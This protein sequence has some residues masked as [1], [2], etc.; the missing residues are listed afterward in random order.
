METAV[1]EEAARFAADLIRIDTTNRG[2]GDARER[3]AA[4]YVAARLTEAGLDPVLLESAPGRANVVVRVSGTGPGG[5]EGARDEGALLLHGHLDVVPADPADWTV[6][7]FA[8]EI[9]DGVLWGRGAVD[10]KNADAVLLALVSGWARD[11]VRPRRDLVL[12]FTAD[13]EDTAEFGAQWLVERH[14]EL[15]EGCTEAIGESGA[16]TF[17]AG[18]GQRL[19]PVA[20]AER[21]TAWLKLTAHGRPGHGAKPNS[22]NAVTRLAQAI[23]RIGEYR[24]PV[25]LIPT[26]R[27]AIDAIAA[28]VGAEPPV[29]AGRAL[30][31]VGAVG[32]MGTELT[33][34]ELLAPLGAAA[35][36]VAGTVRNSANPTML[37]AGYKLNV[38]PGEAVGYVDGR[39]LPGYEGEF[40]TIMD[41]LAGPY[42]SWEYAHQ[43]VPL[44][45]PLEAPLMTSM[46]RTLL[47][48]DPGSTVVPYCMTGGTD[49]KQFARLGMTCYGFTPL[50]LPP[51]YDYYAMFH[52]PDERIPLSAL[53]SG[54]RIMDRLLRA[55]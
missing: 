14:P 41:E 16:F 23:A 4:E 33:V 19:Y 39:V 38:I 24:W 15:F 53:A 31:A 20:S 21:G 12:A 40:E 37:Q 18:P 32:G 3:P 26:V 55:V 13:E 5:E 43:E 45:A 48:E 8:G 6:P 49:G 30:G 11:G 50:V 17:H 9:R 34:E 10:M 1:N 47:A 35:A 51:G 7:P 44:E 22:E 46:A 29:G 2:G 52:G 42:V 36:L 25:R 54:V 27:A 28:A